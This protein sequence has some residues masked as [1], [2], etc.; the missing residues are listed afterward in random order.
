M[1]DRPVNM[2]R[3]MNIGNLNQSGVRRFPK[4]LEA[5]SASADLPDAAAGGG[6]GC[7]HIDVGFVQVRGSGLYDRLERSDI[8]VGNPLKPLRPRN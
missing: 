8:Q 1:T 7:V 5:S 6:H 2:I 3:S 4:V